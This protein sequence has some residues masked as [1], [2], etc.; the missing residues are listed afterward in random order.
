MQAVV[1]VY[2]HH[3][4]NGTGTFEEYPPS[5]VEMTARWQSLHD[6][7][8]PYLV[9][10]Y[11]SELAG[12]AYAG[13]YKQRSA[14]RF[15]VEDSIY[16]SPVHQRLGVGKSLLSA[17]IQCATGNGFKQMMAVIGDSENAGSIGLHRAAGFNDIGVGTNLGFKHGRWLDIVYMQRPLV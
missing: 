9:A 12:F 6:G 7:N 13:P 14:Y 15:T 5:L 1:S 8:Y 16:V 10:E 11:D 4:K 2:S 3:V 17:L